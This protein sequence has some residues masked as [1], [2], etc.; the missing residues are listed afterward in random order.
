MSECKSC[1]N[2]D[3]S[4]NKCLVDGSK[5]YVDQ[6]CLHY[7]CDKYVA[8]KWGTN[9]DERIPFYDD[10]KIQA[11]VVVNWGDSIPP[12]KYMTNNKI[13]KLFT[14]TCK[15]RE[16]AELLKVPVNYCCPEYEPYGKS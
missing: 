9:E 14:G 11:T 15:R 8:G 16:Y 1:E 7:N 2:F 6:K 4:T 5:G 3:L 13:C 10:G 12:C